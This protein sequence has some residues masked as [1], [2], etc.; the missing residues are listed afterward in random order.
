MAV[1][2]QELAELLGSRSAAGAV[3]EDGKE[4]LRRVDDR[5]RLLRLEPLAGVDAAPRDARRVMPAA[6]R[7]ADVERRV[8]DVRGVVRGRRRGA[9][10]RAAS[11]SGSG[12]CRSVS[13]RPTTT[14]KKCSSGRRAN[15]SST[16]ARRFAVTIPSRRPSSLSVVEHAR[17]PGALG[18]LGVQR[19]VVLAVARARARRRA[20]GRASR[21]CSIEPGAADR[22]IS[23]ASGISRP[24]TV[25][26]A[27]R[28]DARMIAPESITVPSRSKRTTGKRIAPIVADRDLASEQSVL[29]ALEVEPP[30]RRRR[31]GLGCA[32][33]PS[34]SA[35]ELVRVALEHRPDERPHHVAQE[36]DR[37]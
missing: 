28:I 15:A 31:A 16:V 24:S 17:H 1:V 33:A 3:S 18:E 26:V 9:R 13:S 7:G 10:A 12:L 35:R 20:P 37:P 21:I 30:R 22:A 2:V 23:S 36:A 29:D 34:S 11:G 32:A 25:F 5:V 4:L 8:A 19:L 27:C 6:L 14:S